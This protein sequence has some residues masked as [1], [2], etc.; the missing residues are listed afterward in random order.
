[1]RVGV[2]SD[3]H[4][5]QD[6]SRRASWHNA[7]DFAGVEHR[8]RRALDLFAGEGVELLLLLGDLAHDGDAPSLRR[9]LAPALGGSTAFVVGGNHDGARPTA[10]LAALGMNGLRLP[11]WRALSVGEGMRVAGVR[12]VRR[13]GR[14]WAA[15]RSPALLTWGEGPVLLATHFPVLAR[16][17]A[18][19]EHGLPHPGDLVNR[20]SLAE[21]L[22]ARRAPTVVLSGH[23]H[24]RDSAASGSLL[25]LGFGALVE[26]PFEA[27]VLEIEGDAAA[28]S[29]GR[30]A[31]EL[32][33]AEE[34]R[35][36][37]LVPARE[38]WSFGPAA[39]GWRREVRPPPAARRARRAAPR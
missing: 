39:A 17:G 31:H 12:V 21:P 32:D 35:D 10:A 9:A 8:L 26:P 34:G 37:R 16:A 22:L 13:A 3:T 25:Q 4:V 24:I 36:P 28:L 19:R 1:L 23:L 2:L 20:A 33:R 27:T 30:A 5:V 29:I 7:Y 15:A 18:M 38:I 6:V 14:G 11:G